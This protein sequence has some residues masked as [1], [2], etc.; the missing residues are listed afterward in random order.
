MNRSQ[1]L[2]NDAHNRTLL[3]NVHP[4]GW[5][6]PTPDGVYNIVIIGG[7]T[8]GLITAAVAAS[9]GARTALIERGFLGGDCLNV[10]CVPS[11][12][13]IRGARGQ[14]ELSWLRE[15]GLLESGAPAEAM[16]RDEVAGTAAGRDPRVAFS[17]VMERLRRI[18]ATISAHD[19]ATRYRDEFGVDVYIGEGRFTGKREIA[20]SGD[21]GSPRELRFA[22]AVIAT[23]ARAAAP[24]I[25]GLDA[26]PYLTNENLFNLTE[27]PESLVVIG[28]GPIGCEMAQSFARLGSR[29][30]LV[31]MAPR[32]LP[33]EDPDVAA[34]I[35]AE[36]ERAGVSLHL[37]AAV[38]GVSGEASE[39]AV[40]YRSDESGDSATETTRT[41]GKTGAA[42]SGAG[43]PESPGTGAGSAPDAEREVR[44]ERLL[45][46]IGRAPNLDGLDLDRAGVR[47][48]PKGVEVDDHLRTSNKRVF[49]VG[50][51]ASPY[52]FTH[53]AEAMASLV[54]QNALFLP[55]GKV[56]HLTVPWSTYTSPEV[57][58]VGISEQEA[59]RQG[60]AVDVYRH[61]M[62][63]VDRARLDGETHGFVKIIA[64]RG[65]TRILGATIVATHAGEMISE[66]VLAMQNGLGID[67]LTSVI[68]P[69]PTQAEAIKRAAA[70]YLRNKLTPR[71]KRIF[72][73]WFRWSRR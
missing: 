46:A 24:P 19:S 65:K 23:G 34:V 17:A 60:I 51:V 13:L 62:A 31:E 37:G 44:A 59:G 58:H 4:L 1:M 42:G 48:H 27:L 64:Q 39:I 25:P 36:L 5:T 67:R 3:D 29:V 21:D 70:G 69:Y 9:M 54:V 38:A 30:E 72:A 55:T 32:V 41:A 12:A 71:V 15:S 16:T 53:M 50:D 40:R 57:A 18:R 45:V 20:V 11:K 43:A 10:G 33:R 68:H 56:S 22:K 2:P 47:Y 14:A 61:E 26:T 73:I 35:Q 52:Q 7:G 28:A 49:A 8:A 66:I 63:K 6:N